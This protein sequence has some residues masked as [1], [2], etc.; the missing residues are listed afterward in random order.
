MEESS[1]KVCT[2]PNLIS[3]A[4]LCLVPVYAVLLANGQNIAATIVFAFAAATDFVDGQVARRTH[5]VSDLGKLLDPAVD[6]ALMVSG[7]IGACAIGA[8]PLWIMVLIFA[9]ELFLLVGGAVLL[10]RF[11]I[12]VPVIYPGKFAT[13]FL[14][15]GIAGLL[16]GEPLVAGLAWCDVAWL[17]GFNAAWVSW[18][19][20]SVYLGLVLQIGVTI[21]YCVVAARA[22]RAV[23][24]ARA[25]AVS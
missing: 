9:R 1:S 17:P 19:I 18:G 25:K 24:D 5:Q 14:F 15:F 7:V 3:L 13:T 20:W 12:H 2:V 21:Y 6:T 22:L 4:R 23:L 11:D 8:L 10:R 16:L